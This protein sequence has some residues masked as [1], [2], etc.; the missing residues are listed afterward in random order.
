VPCAIWLLQIELP[1]V[2]RGARTCE[3]PFVHGTAL[4]GRWVLLGYSYFPFV[5][6]ST[7]YF[8]VDEM[9]ADL[10]ESLASNFRFE[11]QSS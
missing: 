6:I 4:F 11:A 10:D 7:F 9:L 3:F 8:V 2:H 5:S 1:V